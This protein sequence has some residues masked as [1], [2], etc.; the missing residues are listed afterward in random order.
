MRTQR[1]QR[2]GTAHTEDSVVAAG[3]RGA[4]KSPAPPI[5][6]LQTNRSDTRPIGRLRRNPIRDAH[7]LGAGPPELLTSGMLERTA[8]KLKGDPR[9]GRWLILLRHHDARQVKE[10]LAVIASAGEVFDR[11]ILSRPRIHSCRDCLRR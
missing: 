10:L 11:S 3:G 4:D 6:A 2:E 8:P 5:E 9:A 7:A 1:T